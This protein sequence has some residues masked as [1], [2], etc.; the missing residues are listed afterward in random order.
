M[1][2]TAPKFMQKPTA[3]SVQKEYVEKR[4]RVLFANDP[5]KTARVKAVVERFMAKYGVRGDWHDVY[6]KISRQLQAADLTINFD[7][8]K[9]FLTDNQFPSYQQMYERGVKPNGQ[10]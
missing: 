4:Q 5:K 3:Q 1:P 6:V 2:L 9:W 7:A 10:M 8:G